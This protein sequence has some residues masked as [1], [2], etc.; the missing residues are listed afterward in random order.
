MVQTAVPVNSN[1]PLGTI[2]RELR[3]QR[4]HQPKS[5]VKTYTNDNIGASPWARPASSAPL[6]WKAYWNDKWRFGF[7]YPSGWTPDR[8]SSD[9]FVA[10]D[11]GTSEVL[12]AMAET[13]RTALGPELWVGSSS[14]RRWCRIVGSGHWRLDPSRTNEESVRGMEVQVLRENSNG[15]GSNSV[16]KATGGFAAV[17]APGLGGPMVP[18]WMAFIRGEKGTDVLIRIGLDDQATHEGILKTF[19]FTAFYR[20]GLLGSAGP[21]LSPAVAWSG[22]ISKTR[23]DAIYYSERISPQKVVVSWRNHTLPVMPHRPEPK[24]L[25]G[26]IPL[27]GEEWHVIV[28]NCE[29]SGAIQK[30]FHQQV[31]QE[32]WIEFRLIARNFDLY[33]PQADDP[34]DGGGVEGYLKG[35]GNEVQEI[36]YTFDPGNPQTCE[37]D[38]YTIFLSEPTDIETVLPK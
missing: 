11:S 36:V 9:C 17:L 33:A 3:A 32:G 5:K 15:L 1:Q 23:A 21:P 14:D 2:A 20:P 25:D 26:D 18:Q 13:G 7:D 38:S 29:A 30:Y 12:T 28:K 6:G 34:T 31:A 35:D 10:L 19:R 37:G 16:P 22:P 27:K 8:Q 24:S 4:S